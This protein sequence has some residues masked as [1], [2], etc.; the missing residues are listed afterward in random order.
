MGWKSLLWSSAHKRSQAAAS[1]RKVWRRNNYR[2]QDEN[3]LSTPR[4]HI[5]ISSPPSIL[6]APVYNYFCSPNLTS[7][8]L[9][10]RPPLLSLKFILAVRLNGVEVTTP[11]LVS[12]IYP[13]HCIRNPE[14]SWNIWI[15]LILRWISTFLLFVYA[16]WWLIA[17]LKRWENAAD[18]E[19]SHPKSVWYTNTLRR[20]FSAK[21]FA[22][23]QNTCRLSKSGEMKTSKEL[24]IAISSAKFP[25]KPCSERCTQPLNEWEPYKC[26][27]A[28]VWRRVRHPRG[29][30][31]SPLTWW[32]QQQQR[33]RDSN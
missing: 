25:P 17:T 9:L 14:M 16:A 18:F 7:D 2:R 15:T 27:M 11:P 20:L 21:H 5:N 6:T 12:T 3:I 4:E 33:F 13:A 30:R 19:L 28:S 24:L 1:G 8:F 22:A 31:L 32:L 29:R 23:W 26:L 10:L